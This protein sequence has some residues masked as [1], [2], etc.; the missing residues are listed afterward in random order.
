MF[1]ENNV[2]FTIN[3]IVHL[4][5]PLN[6]LFKGFNNTVKGKTKE[7]KSTPVAVVHKKILISVVQV[8]LKIL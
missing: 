1:T 7:Q 5:A 4:K 6:K 2:L 3:K 8:L